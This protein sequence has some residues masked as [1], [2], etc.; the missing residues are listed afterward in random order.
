MDQARNYLPYTV[1][2]A[3]WGIFFLLKV[4]PALFYRPYTSETLE[5]DTK[6]HH[7]LMKHG[8]YLC[9]R[10]GSI[11]GMCGGMLGFGLAHLIPWLVDEST[12]NRN[13]MTMNI[14]RSLAIGFAPGLAIVFTFA[15]F[16][17]RMNIRARRQLMHYIR[18][19]SGSSSL[20]KRHVENGFFM[21][22]DQDCLVDPNRY[23][24][25][26]VTVVVPVYEPPPAFNANMISLLANNPAKILIV[27]DITCVSKIQTIIDSLECDNSHLVEVIP[28]PLPGK[29]AALS[30]GLREVRTRL[31][32][33]VDDDCQWC[34][35]TYLI[36][37]I[38]PFD[39]RTIGGVGSKQIMRPSEESPA[40]DGGE[41]IFRKANI[42]EV[43]ADFRLA[44]R[45]I[46]LMATTAVDRGASCISGRTMCFLTDAIG[47][48]KFHD[49]FMHES[50][51]GIHLLS[52]DDK[53]IT[54]YVIKKGYKTYH[55]LQK[56]CVLTTTFERTR[57]KHMS[58]LIRWSRNTWRSDM[59]ALF[60]ER[61]IWLH[62]PFTAFLLFDKLFTPFFLI[63]G[64]IIIP[65]Y[66]L[67][68]R[69]WVISLTWIIWLLFSRAV[70]LSYHFYRRPDQ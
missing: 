14:Q 11:F 58:Q 39:N 3:R 24:P 28:E 30:T 59:T 13:G 67:S 47:E 55:Q 10:T 16:I 31:T 54:R 2:I 63:Y 65:V 48:E 15:I 53:F 25:A 12:Y 9:I 61:K 1:G 21:D 41:P 51:F 69:D 22:S 44:V 20:A 62:N 66:S 56:G 52:G 4:V 17:E 64:L 6:R 36:D 68:R 50:L 70:K 19:N 29:R 32:C 49:E 26:D 18:V 7:L 37:L 40:E 38:K 43:M 60:I 8:A 45:Y 5:H 34:A 57:K 33:F 23:T 27:A 35:D 46:D 42:L